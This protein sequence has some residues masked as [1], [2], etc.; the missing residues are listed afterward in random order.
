MKKQPFYSSGLLKAFLVMSLASPATWALSD[1]K[2]RE[3]EIEADTAML[4]DTRN[5]SIYTG[6]VVV[7]QG[8]MRI[9]G[10]K[11]TVYYTDD[12]ELEKII[13]EGDLAT[14]RQLPD[15]STIYDEA[16]ARVMEYRENESVLVL[17]GSAFV[18]QERRRLTGARIEYDTETNQVLALGS[19]LESIPKAA[20][21]DGLDDDTRVRL[22]IPPKQQDSAA[23][24]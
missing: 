24:N 6:N 8:S 11:M 22:V 12:R 20:E 1:D 9:T 10:D 13:V 21:T 3:I 19:L 16:E 7:T 2:N 18:S 23:E 4:D 14:F 5:I 17:T 15:S